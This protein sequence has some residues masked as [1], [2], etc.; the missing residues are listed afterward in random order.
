[1]RDYDVAWCLWRNCDADGVHEQ[2]RCDPL[3]AAALLS[4]WVSF[5]PPSTPVLV[6]LR[7]VVEDR[8]M[9]VARGF[10]Y[11]A[12]ADPHSV[13]L[14]LDRHDLAGPRLGV[15]TDVARG[16]DE[17]ILQFRAAVGYYV[18]P[19]QSTRGY[20]QG[21]L[22]SV[23]P[24]GCEI[25]VIETM[26]R[27][28]PHVQLSFRSTE[29]LDLAVQARAAMRAVGMGFDPIDADETETRAQYRYRSDDVWAMPVMARFAA[30]T[31]SEEVAH[32]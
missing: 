14:V 20:L 26:I 1:M 30:A 18:A 19:G 27:G 25:D 17:A 29:R 8:S 24:R 4:Y 32:V 28:E 13:V 6:R 23:L 5:E 12:R 21:L 11:W 16:I 9:W 10:A 3:E 15:S 7:L 2:E 22:L 31:G